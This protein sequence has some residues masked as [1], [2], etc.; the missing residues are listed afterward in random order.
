MD[1]LSTLRAVLSYRRINCVLTLMLFLVLV[2]SS[3]AISQTAREP[4][5]IG[6]I[7]PLTGNLA[8]SGRYPLEAFKMAQD[9]INR[10][11]G[12]VALG[13]R[14]IE[15]VFA[16]HQGM[17]ELATREAER[18]V[19]TN[20]VVALAGSYTSATGLAASA[21]AERLKVPWLQ[22]VGLA[23]T[24]TDRG[25]KFT[26]RNKPNVS[27]F[28]RD[29]YRFMAYLSKL[30]R[31]DI[32]TI[33][34][35]AEDSAYG[36]DG[37]SID[38]KMA[39]S[40]GYTIVADES[41]RQGSSDLTPQL[42]KIKAANAQAILAWNLMPEGLI[43][44]RTMD[45]LEMH[46]PFLP[47]TGGCFGQA[48][49][50]LGTLSENLACTSAWSTDLKLPGVKETNERYRKLFGRD[51]NDDASSAYSGA[52]ILKE[53]LERAKSTDAETL[54]NA[55]AHIQISRGPAMIVPTE[56]SR[57]NFGADGQFHEGTLIV[58]Q[59]QNN[60]YVTVWPEAGASG[61]LRIPWT[62]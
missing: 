42:S 40:L 14:P 13:G 32:K 22:V 58:M 43:I 7:F 20:H 48:M 15:F 44:M 19:K 50:D 8:D 52:Y 18:L 33:A 37:A 57:I 56:N 59:V 34:L 21:V 3:P 41:F 5:K 49:L 62:W 23:D 53:A 2:L 6:I 55:M 35:L 25:L 38:R 16:D 29:R 24:I 27:M 10:S 36:K 47:T 30:A 54:R 39:P 28:A 31:K 26:F 46:M 45:I 61:K 9:E 1:T 12:I 11:G 51:M 60:K 4:V 17:P